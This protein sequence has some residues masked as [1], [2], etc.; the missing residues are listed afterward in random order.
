M[1]IPDPKF[2]VGQE[3][4]DR[5]WPENPFIIGDMVFSYMEGE[6]FYCEFQYKETV[7]HSEH[8]LELV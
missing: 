5:Y 4:V 6:W 7:H 1:E 2:K 8:N 3:V